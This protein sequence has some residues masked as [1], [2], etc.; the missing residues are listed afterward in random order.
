MNVCVKMDLLDGLSC[1][2]C[3][4]LPLER[5]VLTVASAFLITQ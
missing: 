4:T 1:S 3:L 2:G 5:G